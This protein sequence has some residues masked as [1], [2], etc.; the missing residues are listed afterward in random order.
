M[1][2]FSLGLLSQTLFQEILSISILCYE[3]ALWLFLV[4]KL[5]DS[6]LPDPQSYPT[7]WKANVVFP[8]NADLPFHER[9]R[10]PQSFRLHWMCKS[11]THKKIQQNTNISLNVMIHVTPFS[12][13]QDLFYTR[14]KPILAYFLEH[15]LVSMKV[16]ICLFIYIPWSEL[17]FP[18]L[19]L[20][21]QM[22]K[23]LQRCGR[24][25][26]A[27]LLHKGI[28]CICSPTGFSGI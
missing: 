7:D 3:I 20:L 5:Q 21:E 12:E 2:I 14:T 22:V 17:H 28:K 16:L 11:Q 15:Y 10:Y 26:K 4:F 6:W 25:K 1:K 9:H 27:G 13:K 19:C 8:L 24:N 23:E 18:S